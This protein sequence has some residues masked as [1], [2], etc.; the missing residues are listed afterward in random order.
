[1]NVSMLGNYTSNSLINGLMTLAR[2]PIAQL[3]SD[4]SGL[5]VVDAI[6]SDIDTKLTA[7]RDKA[8]ALTDTISSPFGARAASSSDSDVLTA[9]ASSGAASGSHDVHVH[10]LARHHTLLSDKLTGTG[11]DVAT[12]EGAGTKTFNVTVNGITTLVSVDIAADDDNDTIIS[13]VAAAI[14][15][16]LADVDDS[17]SATALKVDATDYR[18]TVRSEETGLAYK[19][20]LADVSGT[21]LGTLGI[22]DEGVAS[23]TTTGG[24][25]Y[26]DSELVA[27]I[28]IDGVR[29][30]RDSN[31]ISDVI[32]DVT[33]T[34]LGDQESG[35]NDLTL[36]VSP[37]AT[38]IR[39]EVDELLTAYNDALAYLRL[40][41][42]VDADTGVRG[43][44]AG[45]YTYSN[46]ILNVRSVMADRVSTI[47][48]GSLG[49]LS[50]IGIEAAADGSLSITD[51]DEF[52]E[53]VAASPDN[54]AEL[55]NS[56]D[57]VAA[58]LDSILKPFVKVGGYVDL[59]QN[60]IDRKITAIE[61]RIDRLE[62]RVAQRE[63]QLIAQYSSV[64]SMMA[65]L[66]AQQSFLSSLYSMY[67]M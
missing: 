45:K 11:T 17:V 4:K 52:D 42:S 57:G 44:L 19:V 59:S 23:T 53:A 1:M 63:Q 5:Q 14:N 25:V 36:S 24:Y 30:S 35:D 2:R 9:T 61:L 62:E 65:T 27:D 28:T 22:D 51:T 39:G 13:A 54:V 7:L 21:L 33:L 6:Y 67:G 34:L 56:A 48:A 29:V 8:L 40:K 58:Q 43:A 47:T 38:S 66:N 20:T 50:E 49:S 31:T 12:A 46:L 15:E 3:E 41:T 64:Q 26:S 60:G 37:D 16:D 10:Q 18:L 32:E 55:F